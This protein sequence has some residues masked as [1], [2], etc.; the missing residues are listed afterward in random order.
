MFNCPAIWEEKVTLV[1][2]K[3]RCPPTSIHAFLDREAKPSASCVS[4]KKKKRENPWSTH[5]KRVPG[6][7][8]QIE[9][10]TIFS[11]FSLEL[12]CRSPDQQSKVARLYLPP[13][14]CRST[15]KS[16]INK[17][18]FFI[19]RAE[20]LTKGSS[21]EGQLSYVIPA[22]GRV[23]YTNAPFV[24]CLYISVLSLFEESR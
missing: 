11:L 2:Y 13:M 23:G 5:H 4:F 1:L 21:S 16:N 3:K 8:N 18:G 20:D 10:R 7:Q 17:M 22:S 9:R 12:C 14:S 24:M 6:R 15:A 19:I